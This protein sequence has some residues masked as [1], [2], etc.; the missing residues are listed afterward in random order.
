MTAQK[1]YYV[2]ATEIVIENNNNNNNNNRFV[3]H[4]NVKRLP[5]RYNGLKPNSITLASSELDPN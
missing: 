3:K 4:K 1:S 5:W 2:S